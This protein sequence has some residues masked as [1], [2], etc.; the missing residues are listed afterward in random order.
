[1]TPTGEN[2]KDIMNNPRAK[3]AVLWT[4][5]VLAALIVLSILCSMSPAK[6]LYS[7][8]TEIRMPGITNQT[9]RKTVQ[10]YE[11]NVFDARRAAQKMVEYQITVDI[12][13]INKIDRP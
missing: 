3:A 13:S 12:R 7:V 10:V 9:F 2:G 1:M 5:G 8:Q 11:S 6:I 4:L